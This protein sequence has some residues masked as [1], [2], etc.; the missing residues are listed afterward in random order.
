VRLV[1]YRRGGRPGIGVMVEDSGL[2]VLRNPI[3]AEK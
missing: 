3:A 1:S 2:G